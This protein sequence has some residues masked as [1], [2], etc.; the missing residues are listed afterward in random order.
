MTSEF[1]YHG[2]IDILPVKNNKDIVNDIKEIFGYE[3]GAGVSF[4]PDDSCIVFE[5]YY[6]SDYDEFLELL[7]KTDECLKK[8]G[9]GI[10]TKGFSIEV[11]DG[12]D[13]IGEIIANNNDFVF[14]DTEECGIYNASDKELLD[15]LKRRG[16]DYE[17]LQRLLDIAKDFINIETENMEP[18]YLRKVFRESLGISRNEAE[19]LGLDTKFLFD[20][21]EEE[22]M[23][24]K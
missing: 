24:G 19:Q 12:Y 16:I 2:A 21:E 20:N 4:D 1:Y 7:R 14:I 8:R 23:E 3:E 5:G 11:N 9:S 18:D 22:D 15:E 10:L 17:M 6:T 13:K